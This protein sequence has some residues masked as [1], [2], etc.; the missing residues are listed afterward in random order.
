MTATI[1]D[2]NA[3]AKALRERVGQAIAARVA[4]GQV[5]PGLAVVLVGEDPASQVYV[6]KKR[7]AC[8]AL[9]I[10]SLPHNL[11]ADTSETELLDLVK[12][13]NDDPAVDGILVQLPLPAHMDAQKVIEH[14]D[15]DKD[16][17]GFHP[18][19]VGRLTLRLP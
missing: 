3:I 14:I 18:V 8:E 5:A 16:V 17:D 12:Q 1:I 4:R 13:L 7:E 11:P 6:R 10:R 15:P 2:G 19:S 9:G